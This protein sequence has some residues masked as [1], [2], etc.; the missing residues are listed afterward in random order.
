KEAGRRCT[1]VYFPGH[2]LPMLPLALSEKVCSLKPD[3][4]RLCL[5]C[6]MRFAPDGEIGGYDFCKA[7]IRS[8]ARLTYSQSAQMLDLPAES[9]VHESLLML[10][11]LS[12]KL[13]A[14][15]LKAGALKLFLPTPELVLAD[16]R[17]TGVTEFVPLRTHS[18]IEECMLVANVCAA[19]FLQA[20]Q[21]PLL[22]RV[23]AKPEQL[24][25]EQLRF[26]LREYGIGVGDLEDVRN[27]QAVIDAVMKLPPD[28]AHALTFHVLRTL[29]RAVY[30]PNKASH[31]GLGFTDY[32]HFTSP[33]RRY[34]DLL[35]HR[36]I[37][38]VL[39]G[40]SESAINA[41]QLGEVGERCSLREQNA[42]KAERAIVG[43]MIA[44]LQH[45][46]VGQPQD[47]V[48]TGITKFGIFVMFSG[49][50]EGLLPLS[51][52]RDD[53]Y[54][55]KDKDTVL[56]GSRTKRMFRVGMAVQVAIGSI[57]MEAGRCR[58]RLA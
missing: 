47:G 25:I 58:L 10:D 55:L 8:Q 50:A 45:S 11:E 20:K 26:L 24:R 41:T 36:Q 17:V 51:Q 3:E 13:L 4:D 52:L 21:R 1:S 40:D 49:F 35:V 44:R 53:Y 28:R 38:S 34:P 9:P 32:T 54:E 5:A 46:N 33:I 56:L 30:T 42:E 12:A 29:S 48:I 2:V 15:R 16:D 39:A 22:Y 57:D 37:S 23:H 19:K 43:R 6:R 7:V 14:R 18:I 27:M 31:Y